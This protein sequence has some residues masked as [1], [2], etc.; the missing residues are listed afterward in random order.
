MC[1]HYFPMI[2]ICIT[3]LPLKKGKSKD[4]FSPNVSLV[5]PYWRQNQLFSL[6]HIFFHLYKF[7][8]STEIKINLKT[9][10][11]AQ[12]TYFFSRKKSLDCTHSLCLGLWRFFSISDLYQV[13]IM[14]VVTHS[15]DLFELLISFDSGLSVLNFPL[16]SVFLWF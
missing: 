14:I 8:Q 2:S 9:I 13:L 11:L 1:V 7:I 4:H 15:F 5:M 10:F 3:V 12:Q 6:C 16:G